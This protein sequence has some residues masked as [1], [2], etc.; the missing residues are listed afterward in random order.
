[1]AQPKC[2]L[3]KAN[4]NQKYH[5]R[6]TDYYQCTN[7]QSLFVGR[8]FLPSKN[9]ERERY[10]QHNNDVNDINYQK[11][12]SP[13][14]NTILNNY[15]PSDTG[16]D[17]GAGT[18]PVIAKILKD[19]NFNIKTYD[20]FF[21]FRP[22]LLEEKYNYIVCCEVMEH[23]FNPDDEFALLRKLL[24]PGGKL[25]CMTTLYHDSIEFKSWKYKDDNTHVFLYHRKA[26]DWI[27]ETFDFVS[28]SVHEKL[29]IFST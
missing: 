17:F 12:V 15:T 3:C 6:K 13:I 10:L 9:D 27:R 28:V 11:F 2:P 20:P 8:E 19:N 29:I 4:S 14:S 5:Y 22:E 18:G 7:C 23:F 16:L 21:E 1:M 25:Y 24:K 26:L